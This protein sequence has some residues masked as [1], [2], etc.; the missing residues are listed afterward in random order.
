MR[1]RTRLLR[2]LL[3]PRLYLRGLRSRCEQS[4]AEVALDVSAASAI[5]GN[6]LIGPRATRA[7]VGKIAAGTV[8]KVVIKDEG[9]AD[10]G[11]ASA[12][13]R[14]TKICARQRR[15]DLLQVFPS[16]FSYLCATT[17]RQAPE[18]QH[19]RYG[20]RFRQ[21]HVFFPFDSK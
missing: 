2:P 9:T 15:L 8:R 14:V 17:S 18:T 19:K 1:P 7:A 20:K 4:R 6:S 3:H 10:A 5:D 13:W 12:Y 11:E 21:L 16:R